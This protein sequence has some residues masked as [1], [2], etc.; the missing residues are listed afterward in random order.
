[1]GDGLHIS[2][3]TDQWTSAGWFALFPSCFSFAMDRFVRSPQFIGD[4]D[5]KLHPNLST[6]SAAELDS[7]TK[8]I[9]DIQVADHNSESDQRLGWL[10]GK[11]LCTAFFYRQ[12]TTPLHPLPCTV[13]NMNLFPFSLL[14]SSFFLCCSVTCFEPQTLVS[15]EYSIR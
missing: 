15:L 11:P 3:W 2:F 9:C 8:I 4:R 12:L 6:T 13:P 14:F 10:N 1:M 5:I 7:C